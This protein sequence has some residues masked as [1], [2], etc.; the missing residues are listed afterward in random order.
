MKILILVFLLVE[1]MLIFGDIADEKHTL[2]G[3]VVSTNI[4]IV[5]NNN[6]S[7]ALNEQHKGWGKFYSI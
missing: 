4:T 2:D 7:R 6:T 1:P 3:N 5:D